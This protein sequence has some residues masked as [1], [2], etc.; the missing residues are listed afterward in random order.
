[1]IKINIKKTNN[2]ITNLQ[3]SN[4]AN[5]ADYGKDIVCAAV[6]VLSQAV[7]NSMILALDNRDDFFTV[8]EKTG[9]ITIDVPQEVD[10]IQQIKL[11]TLTQMLEVSFRD[12]QEQYENNI[13][14]NF[15]EVE[16][17]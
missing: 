4:H 1:M 14:L 15:E 3:I 7:V 16:I 17:W 5:Y 11:D 12:L 13:S 6:S 2:K 10:N 9:Q 8:D